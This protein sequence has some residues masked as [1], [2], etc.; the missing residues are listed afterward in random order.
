LLFLWMKFWQAVFLNGLRSQISAQQQ[1][2]WTIRRCLRMFVIQTAI[3]P[4]A[5]LMLP[6]AVL[7]LLVPF[8][9]AYAFYQNVTALTDG[10]TGEISK[11]FK[12][13]WKQ[14]TLWPAQNYAI[15]VLLLAFAF[16]VF[17]N[18]MSACFLLP[19]LLKTLLGIDSMY[20][21]SPLSM[22]NTTMVTAVLGLTYLCVDPIAKTAYL[23]RCFYGE[24]LQSGED[25]K[26]DLKQLAPLTTQAA[27]VVIAFILICSP[28]RAADEPSTAAPD[29]KP[30]PAKVEPTAVSAPTLDKTIKDVL[31]QPKYTWRMPR[32]KVITEDAKEGPVMRFFDSVLTWIKHTLKNALDWLD[33]WLRKLFPRRSLGS[34]PNNVNWI[35]VP[36]ALLVVLVVVVVCVL[37]IVLLRVWQNRSPNPETVSTEA[38]GPVPDLKD[39]NVAADQLPEDGWIKLGRE[40]LGRGEFRLALRAFYF[41]S[42]SHLAS[43]SLSS[44]AKFKSN[45]DY[46]R[47]LRRRGHSLPDLLSL[48]GENV[49]VF[50]RV[51]YGLHDVNQDIIGNFLVNVEKI[52]AAA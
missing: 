49:S 18:L 51:W 19:E 27:A 12:R 40:L 31:H 1:S 22:F 28:C 9:W 6:L 43:R 26:A 7:A 21:Q 14:S 38:I 16:F 35:G 25:L 8:G 13:A 29:P 46:E 47:E 37:A 15:F 36:Q 52:K 42:L 34:S 33:K 5:V 3:Q 44:I 48:F 45:R 20:S 24:A 41:A 50:D 4:S 39:E 30:A 11:V 32:E 17:L 23:L 2:R 10:E